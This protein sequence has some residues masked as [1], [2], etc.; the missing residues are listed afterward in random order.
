MEKPEET[1]AVA[2]LAEVARPDVME[3]VDSV[4][5]ACCSWRNVEDW[6]SEMVSEM[7]S[8]SV[9]PEEV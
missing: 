5:L 6:Q 4:Q 3:V 1:S 9:L 2:E 7:V 8:A